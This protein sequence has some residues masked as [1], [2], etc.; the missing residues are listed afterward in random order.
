MSARVTVFTAD[1]LALRFFAAAFLIAIATSC[2]VETGTTNDVRRPWMN[3]LLQRACR[4]MT[5]PNDGVQKMI[6]LLQGVASTV[7]RLLQ[8]Q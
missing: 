8:V 2:C 5:D 3:G 1:F 6:D 4:G 7:T